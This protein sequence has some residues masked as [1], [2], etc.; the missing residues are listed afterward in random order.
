MKRIL[1]IWRLAATQP[2]LV[3]E[4]RALWIRKEIARTGRQDYKDRRWMGDVVEREEID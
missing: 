4:E 2:E 1:S 3:V